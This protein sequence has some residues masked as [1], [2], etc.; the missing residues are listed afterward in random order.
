M[1]KQYLREGRGGCKAGQRGKLSCMMQNQQ[2]F[3]QPQLYGGGNTRELGWPV[4][5]VRSGA[6]LCYQSREQ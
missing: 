1:R 3:R 5:V 2:S 6:L 4:G